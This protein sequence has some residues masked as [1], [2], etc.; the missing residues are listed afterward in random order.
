MKKIWLSSSPKI[1][2]SR[3]KLALRFVYIAF[4]VLS[5]SAFALYAKISWWL[6]STHKIDIFNELDQVSW[7]FWVVDPEV[8]RQLLTLDTILKEYV[9]WENVLQT[10]EKELLQL[11]EYAKENTDYL[12][13]LWFGNYERILQMLNA[14]WPMR[15]EIFELLGK[16][17][18]FNY[19]VPLQNS[20]EA[21]PNGGFF[22]SFAFISLSW[23]HIVDMQI[24][25]SY[26]P[27]LL[28][29]KTRIPLPERTQ[30]FLSEKTA[31]FIWGNKF[32]FT[33]KDGKNL[34]TLYEKIFHTDFDPVKKAQMFNPE[35]RNQLFQKD[36]KGIVFL[37]SELI[38]YLLPSFRSK[39]WEWQFLNANVDL[40]RGEDKS[41]KKEFYIKD[42]Q[43]YL[44]ENALSLAK[45][46]INN[47]QELLH[48]GF[49][50]VYL[51][52]VSPELRGF[53]QSYDLTTVYD[54]AF[55]Y[56]FNI[57]TSFNKSDG[58]LK[59]QVEIQNASGQVVLATE[60]KK[61][62]ISGLA[63]GKYTLTISYT[64]DIP[65]SYKDEMFALEKKWWIKMTDRERYILALQSKNP[66]LS[67]PLRRRSTKEV[68][69]F[70]KNTHISNFR[71]NAYGFWVFDSDFAK[72]VTYQ[73]QIATNQTTNTIT[74]EVQL[75]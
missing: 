67:Q 55:L 50:N 8:A 69:Y 40:I 51:S 73:S 37:D 31:G 52:N 41:N 20:N 15:E 29:P 57:N 36:I 47:T 30:G 23:G 48:K 60:E 18:R 19:L 63:P 3:A 25:D 5:F 32:W 7:Y 27:D 1:P 22:G 14:A 58:F 45:A 39:S 4:L 35:Q 12:T 62:N 34:K 21:R 28:A 10:K 46:M 6:F 54:P 33:D 74:L 53:L 9:A 70:P 17:Q 11:W 43:N 65:K 75:F 16:H 72:W 61:L 56:F 13:R 26:L 59:K 38:S 68:I 42:I 49:V 66:D 2:F 71:G 24:I 44:K 64:L